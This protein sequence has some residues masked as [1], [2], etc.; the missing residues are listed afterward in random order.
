MK[1]ITNIILLLALFVF[2][3]CGEEFL[4]RPSKTQ[5]DDSNF[6]TS[7]QNLRLFV[8]GAYENYF[9]GYANS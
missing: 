5:M 8:N 6:W 7:E 4:N 1:K 9:N 2:A 3:S